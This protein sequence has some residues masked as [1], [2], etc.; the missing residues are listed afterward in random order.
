M[1]ANMIQELYAKP[2]RP[3]MTVSGLVIVCFML[4]V[5]VFVDNKILGG[6]ND[7]RGRAPDTKPCG[8]T[9]EDAVRKT[10]C[11]AAL[12]F[13]GV[14]FGFVTALLFSFVSLDLAITICM[15]LCTGIVLIA[16]AGNFI[17]SVFW[18]TLELKFLCRFLQQDQAGE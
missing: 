18:G 5:I 6:L 3:V 4:A 2:W 8:I 10:K 9:I 7:L 12:H 1:D 14:I 13:S 17:F 11:T 16:F 15:F